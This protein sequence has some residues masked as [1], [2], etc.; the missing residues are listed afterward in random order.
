AGPAASGR[1][2]GSVRRTVVAGAAALAIALA[3]GVV[4]GFIGY[5]AHGESG[6]PLQLPVASG[7]SDAAP[8]VDRSSL[9]SIAA[10]LQPAIVHIRT[11]AGEG[12]GVVISS[13]GH[14]V[15]NNHVIAGVGRNGVRV[16]FNS[17]RQVPATI[18]G[19]D[20]QTDIAVIKVDA[21]NL[22]AAPWGDSD[23]VQVGDTVLA[24]GS[25]LGL[26]GSV[27]A[28]IVSAL[29]RTIRVTEG[30]RS[31]FDTGSAT[32][33]GG[34]IQTDAPINA[35]NSGGALVN[36]RGEVIGINTAIATAGL[37][38]NIGVG[39][40]ISS[41]R[42]KSVAD[43][44]IAGRKV[45]HPYIGVQITDDEDG[46]AL[47][48]SVVEGSPA[49][50]AGLAEG[51][52]VTKVGDRPIRGTDELIGIIQ[53]STVGEKLTL[54]VRRDGSERTVTVTIGEQ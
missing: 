29:N 3:G 10:A 47:I 34:A 51:D 11:D 43:A 37:N 27:T 15:T 45:T 4:G 46:G 49:Q 1:Q 22:T 12:S 44:L 42:A 31:Q 9:S 53:S 24:I 50:Q 14:I 16:T 40:A 20:A 25:P 5:A 33:I 26:Q 17:G 18:V 30:P 19:A 6:S 13:D 2:P 36:M 35:G 48:R 39:F 41:N 23:A 54:T 21:E 8:V 28:G 38:G 7:N 52:V 32:V